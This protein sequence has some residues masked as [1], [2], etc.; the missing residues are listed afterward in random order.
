MKIV[1]VEAIPLMAR[2]QKPLRMPQ[3]VIDAFYTTVVRIETDE[4]VTGVGECIVR[5]SP[6]VTKTIVEQMFAPLLLGRDPLEVEGI[7]HTLFDSQRLRGHISGF[8]MEALSGVDMALWDILGRHFGLPIG[9]LMGGCDRK[10]VPVYASSIMLNE[11]HVMEREAEMLLER[12]F[13]AIKVKV[14]F[15]LERDVS[16]LKAIRGVVGWDVGL[17]ADANSSYRTDRAVMLGRRLEEL[18]YRWLEEPVLPDDSEGYRKLSEKLDITL[19]AGES[20]FS[21]FGVKTLI[22]EGLIGMV[23]PDVSRCGGYTESRRI[24]HLAQIHHIPYAP[25]TGF[26]SAICLFASMQLAAWAPNFDSFEYM[27]IDNPLLHIM[28]EDIPEVHDG[29]L[30]IPQGVG[31]GAQLNEE[32]IER[33]RIDR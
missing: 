25:H 22:E 23:Q 11:Q 29:V 18:G 32:L 5:K 15:G 9:K 1:H 13:R 27:Y 33:Y 17:M 7:W 4:G 14:G 16:N 24:A 3:A 20:E 26:S 30:Q 21:V 2:P 28:Q 31:L 12:G 10:Q 6:D 19:A 8:F